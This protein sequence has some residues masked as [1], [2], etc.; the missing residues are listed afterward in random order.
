MDLAVRAN[1]PRRHRPPFRGPTARTV[2]FVERARVAAAS[3]DYASF[4]AWRDWG[5][6]TVDVFNIFAA[7]ALQSADGA[8]LLGRM[9]PSTSAAGQWVFPSG[10][11]D[12]DDI[13]STGS[14]DLVGNV[15]REL[16]E[17]TGL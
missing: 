15:G 17:E 4:L 12:P 10:T 1:P 9:A 14:L 3:T 7:A 16:F 5:C 6:P 8:F 11:P 13:N 2:G